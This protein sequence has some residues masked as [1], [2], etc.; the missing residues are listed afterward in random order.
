M[1]LKTFFGKNQAEAM[2]LVRKELGPEALIISSLQEPKGVRITAAVEGAAYAPP[3]PEPP[4]NAEVHVINEL[5]SLLEFHRLPSFVS[6]QILDQASS[7]DRS[8]VAQGLGA[9][10]AQMG[11]FQG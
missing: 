9:V 2:D 1:R 8:I 10:F 6:E 3:M 5:I 7:I 11:G 4:K